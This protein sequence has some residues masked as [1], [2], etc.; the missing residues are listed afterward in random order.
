[1]SLARPIQDLQSQN[2]GGGRTDSVNNSLFNIATSVNFAGSDKYKSGVASQR[3]VAASNSLNKFVERNT[4]TIK[5]LST[6]QKESIKEF[7]KT[8]VQLKDKDLKNFDDSIDT[9]AKILVK[10]ESTLDKDN[11]G[12]KELLKHLNE[13]VKELHKPLSFKE[14]AGDAV[15]ARTGFKG[16]FT[17]QN[18]FSAD[19]LFKEGSLLHDLFGKKGSKFDQ[20]KGKASEDLKGEALLAAVMAKLD[21]DLNAGNKKLHEDLKKVD[22]DIKGSKASGKESQVLSKD[23][24]SKLEDM[25]Y[26]PRGTG[27]AKDNKFVSN[28]EID[29]AIGQI[30]ATP[31]DLLFNDNVPKDQ[32]QK[33][34]SYDMKVADNATF[35][36]KTIIFDAETVE[37][38]GSGEGG[39]SMLG[40]VLD[41]VGG[42][43]GKSKGGK[44]GRAGKIGGI[45]KGAGIL[46]AAMT[47]IDSGMGA[48]ADYSDAAEKEDKGIITK[49]EAKVAKGT[50]VGK[51]VGGA[52][53]GIVGGLKGAAAGAAIGSVV[54]VVGTAVGGLVG[55]AIGAFGG[56]W[57]GEKAGAWLG[58]KAAG[59]T[60]G[61]P[62]TQTMQYDAMGNPTGMA[63]VDAPK[64]RSLSRTS[65][66]ADTSL[67][68]SVAGKGQTPTVIN[69]TTVNNKGSEG[70]SPPAIILP[71]RPSN[72]TWER[73][74][75]RRFGG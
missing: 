61:T 2:G 66:I 60:Q 10:L 36:A 31:K 1:M 26:K 67:N 28:K 71:I 24:L 18:M 75:D 63:A 49:E 22:A 8:V 50:A 52:A 3:G 55:G 54:P 44:V 64:T 29:K 39:G 15:R 47:V 58:G 70:S 42:G 13:T 57:L 17:M 45:V 41:S 32:Q 73:F 37:G 43:K 34:D 46:G 48:Y 35:K 69:N 12:H 5:T 68:N 59:L 40:D 30:R 33:V 6:E 62:T 21:K 16:D 25:G 65:T 4:E 53:G 38:L 72:N 56:S 51:G 14:R 11:E 20:A 19:N 74:Q 7:T 23:E 27:F 9:F